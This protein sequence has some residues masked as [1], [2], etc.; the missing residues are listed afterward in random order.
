M[1][2][3]WGGLTVREQVMVHE[4]ALRTVDGR[5]RLGFGDRCVGSLVPGW[6]EA[7]R[8]DGVSV[9]ANERVWWS[10]PPYRSPDQYESLRG[11]RA[12]LKEKNRQPIE[13]QAKAMQRAGGAHK[14]LVRAIDRIGRRMSRR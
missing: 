9:R 4:L 11:M 6:M 14:Q 13:G 12:A 7:R 8:L 10:A 1:W 5:R 2:N 3:T